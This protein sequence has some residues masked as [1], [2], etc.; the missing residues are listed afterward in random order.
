[1]CCVW[2]GLETKLQKPMTSNSNSN[3]ASEQKSNNTTVNENTNMNQCAIIVGCG[4]CLS[5]SI[6]IKFAKEGYNLV[7]V[8]R[9]QE[10]SQNVATDIK[11]LSNVNVNVICISADCSDQQLCQKE[12]NEKILAN[13]ANL[14]AI[15]VLVYN[16]AP[17]IV[18][19]FPSIL[20]LTIEQFQQCLTVGCTGFLIWCKLVIPEMLKNNTSASASATKGTILVTGATA[21]LRGAANFSCLSAPK[22]A[23]RSLS[24]SIAREFHPQ[25]IHLCH[26][27]LDGMIGSPKMMKMA[28]N[29]PKNEL[30]S[31]DGCAYTYYAVAQQPKNAW[32]HEIDLRPNTEK[33]TIN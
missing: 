18:F 21:S 33:W 12:F 8:S 30:L 7:L 27:I 29:K 10:S 19:P 9:R 32:S 17:P 16:T 23:L 13:N 25:S 2:G 5:R 1:L 15:S 11:N 26:F 4:P 31:C 6:A 20:D 3:N 14:G 22:F 24:Q 28:A